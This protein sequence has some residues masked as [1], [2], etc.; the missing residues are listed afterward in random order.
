MAIDRMGRGTSGDTGAVVNRKHVINAFKDWRVSITV[1]LYAR[2]RLKL[3][4]IYVGGV[5]YF[6][7][8]TALAG[9]SAFLPTIIKTFGYS[10]S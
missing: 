1:D 6:G 7:A 5:I 4:Q 10:K 3:S 2:I 8:N 9:I